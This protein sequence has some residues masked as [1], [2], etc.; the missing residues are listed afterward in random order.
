MKK[1]LILLILA[2]VPLLAGMAQNP[3]R[4]D[5]LASV[6]KTGIV[7]GHIYDST[8]NGAIE[9]ATVGLYRLDDSSLVNGTIT[10]QTGSFTIRNLPYGDFYLEIAFIGYTKKQVPISLTLQQFSVDL[11]AV[12]LHPD[13]THIGEVEIVAQSQQVEYKIDKKVV[14]VSQ[15]IAASGGTL[16]NVLENTPSVQVDVEGNVSL[17][18][19]ENFQV[20]IDGKPSVIQGSEG[21][22]QIPAS[23]VQSLEI[24]TS[25]SAKYDPDGAAGIINVIM[26]KQKNTGIGGLVNFSIGTRQKYTA[27]FLLNF[28]KNKLNYFIGGEYADQNNFMKGKFERRSYI[29]DTTTSTFSNV[30]GRFTRAS[31]NLKSGF[32]FYINDKSTV[33]FSGS[34]GNRNFVRDFRSINTWSTLPASKD[35]FYTDESNGSDKDVFYNLNFDY[36]KKYDDNGHNLQASVYYSAATEDEAE[37]EVIRKTDSNFNPVGTDPARTR[38]RMKNPESNLRVEIDY[39]RPV[40][41]GK[42]ELGLQSR[43]DKHEGNYIFE[44]FHPV[45]NEWE[46]NDS[47]SNSLNYLD[48]LQSVYGMYSAPLG[49]FEYQLGLR[50]E[51][52]NRNLDQKTSSESFTYDKM[53]FFPSFYVIRR[54]SD[55]HQFQLTF[56]TRIQRPEM[57]DL[58]PFKEYRGSNNIFFGNPALTPEFTNSFELN[59][60]YTFKKG[61]ISLETYYRKTRD[62]MT[63][64]NGIDTIAGQRL[65]FN[66]ITNADKD[67]SLGIELMTNL[68]LTKWWQLNLTGNLFRYELTG[69]VD[70]SAV[71]TVS[72]SWRTNFNSSFKLKWDTRFQFSGFYNGPS[73]TLQGKRDGF[74]VANMA[75]R[76]DFLKKQLSVAINARDVFSTGVFAFTSEGSTFYTRN[77]IRRESPVV[78]LNLTYRINNYK[79]AANRRDNNQQEMNGMDEG[80]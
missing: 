47:I 58:N 16:V 48:V 15:D 10:D 32:D 38:S 39:A 5:E 6:L 63:R 70:G 28:K 74:F 76:K 73:N 52:D 42:V 45:G 31:L 62:K 75:L 67:N 11:G 4:T 19:S 24:I 22:Q 51:Y 77:R 41:R 46:H 44:N 25:P 61:S 55:A 13:I 57:R 18:G 36:Q 12:V 1:K 78:T 29:N 69:E 80:M 49:K 59:Y 65:F 23:A 17:R 71:S 68:N 56:S 53:H 37:S 72:T 60:Q 20:L 7:K 3:Q 34:I 43:W 14:N 66:T 35:S 33:S 50:A 40:G 30:D 54:L 79:Q 27:D 9:Y 21:L 26:K 8:S 64:I 2:V